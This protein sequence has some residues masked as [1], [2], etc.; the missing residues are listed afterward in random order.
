MPGTWRPWS[1]FFLTVGLLLLF[2]LKIGRLADLLQDVHAE[3]VV[4]GAD[5]AMLKRAV[6]NNVVA[7]SAQAARLLL[8]A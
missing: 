1:L 3:L 5:I 6:S 7:G 2:V 4:D 8:F